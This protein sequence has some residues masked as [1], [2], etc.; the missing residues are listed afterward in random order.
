MGTGSWLHDAFIWIK[1]SGANKLGGAGMNLAFKSKDAAELLIRT[2]DAACNLKLESV[3]PKTG[4]AI[5][6]L[7]VTVDNEEVM[8]SDSTITM[9]VN[10]LVTV[11]GATVKVQ[12]T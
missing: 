4:S 6:R 8:F 5:L 12:V 1:R 11:P 2:A 9:Y 7:I 10:D 3:D